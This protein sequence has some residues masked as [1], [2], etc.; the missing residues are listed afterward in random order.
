M[1]FPAGSAINTLPASYRPHPTISASP[2]K[3]PEEI[4]TKVNNNP[5]ELPNNNNLKNLIDLYQGS[6]KQQVENHHH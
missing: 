1:L 4:I 2:Y 3:L 6:L 5:P